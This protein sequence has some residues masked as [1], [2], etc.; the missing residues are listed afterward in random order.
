MAPKRELDA[1][2]RDYLQ[3]EDSAIAEELLEELVFE[4]AQ[5]LVEKIVAG[6]LGHS[7]DTAQDVDDVC[8][9][10]IL[11]ILG[12]L[13]D[14][15]VGGAEPESS[16]HG[17]VAV[18]SYHACDNYFRHRFPQ[19]HRLKNRLRYLLKPERGFDLWRDES[20]EWV[21]GW[22]GWRNSGLRT[23]RDSLS[24][25]LLAALPE[26]PV[27]F[28][29]ALFDRVGR[30]M[31]FDEVVTVAALSWGIQDQRVSLESAGY[32]A[33]Q[34]QDPEAW[35]SCAQ[36]AWEEIRILPRTQRVALLLNLRGEGDGSAVELFPLTGVASTAE[37]AAV[38]EIP[39]LEFAE[40]WKRLPLGDA[41]IANR[42][43]VTRQQVIN[44]RASA[45][46]RLERRMGKAIME[47]NQRL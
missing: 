39:V 3:A 9:E 35:R 46:R 5:P 16:F 14:W 31:E 13:E 43:G 24:Q 37:L 17:Y 22:A 29:G 7:A 21:C 4:G 30:P 32:E 11:A 18:T 26:A 20:G 44:L 2:V 25:T 28:L 41:E 8:A 36:R 33:P 6:K 38:L 19:R 34:A 45:R 47:V 23:S 42:L 40:I 1:V 10:A 27:P 12:K 15:K